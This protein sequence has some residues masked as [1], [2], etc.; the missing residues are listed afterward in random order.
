MRVLIKKLVLKNFRAFDNVEFKFGPTSHIFGDNGKGKSSIA[1]GIVF[2]LCGVN[3]YGSNHGLDKLIKI[4]AEPKVAEATVVV[5]VNGREY[6][7]KRIAKVV[8]EPGKPEE[9]KTEVFINGAKASSKAVLEKVLG[10]LDPKQF[11]LGFSPM[12][13]DTLSSN[14][15]QKIVTS[16]IMP[17]TEAEILEQLTPEEKEILEQVDIRDSAKLK[18]E[19]SGL[20]KKK[21]GLENQA[22]L[23]KSQ[24]AQLL[25]KE[26]PNASQDIKENLTALQRK[27]KELE[28]S[29][30]N[31]PTL[32]EINTARLKQQIEQLRKKYS[33][34][35]V[36]FK[37]GDTCP[38]CGQNVT[39]EAVARLEDNAEAQK[40]EIAD[41]GKALRAELKAAEEKNAA[42]R[43][44]YNKALEAW[45]DKQKE[46]FKVDSEIKT[47]TK[48]AAEIESRES[49]QIEIKASLDNVKK[50]ISN[51]ENEIRDCKISLSAL[52]AYNLKA[53]ELHAEKLKKHLGRVE[54]KLFDVV[55]STG[56]LVPTFKLLYE[57]K[58]QQF[59]STSEKVRVGL[60][61]A[62]MFR[63]LSG[64]NIPCFIDNAECISRAAQYADS[65]TQYFLAWVVPGKNE[66][67]VVDPYGNKITETESIPE[68]KAS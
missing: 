51:I 48:I 29:L 6:T 53:N 2:A 50:E 19:L 55:K 5:G 43:E 66:L 20:E 15:L 58:P 1:E 25:E 57:S 4:D 9:T 38:S 54:I 64:I 16:A 45:R 35:K 11:L 26:A 52:S 44:S 63:K 24:L 7:V 60:E 21:F 61:L 47:L 40:K 37:A 39:A 46:L 36:A 23:L 13:Y 30:G 27:R 34:I 14:E 18:K 12:Y 67:E 33:S 59:L 56:E 3:I 32:E 68:E 28:R 8:K 31:P 17:P 41:A 62:Q 10:R 22:E 65:D 42:T 49:R